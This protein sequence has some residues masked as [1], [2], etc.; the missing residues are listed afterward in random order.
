MSAREG[1]TGLEGLGEAAQK[2]PQDE[3]AARRKLKKQFTQA[4]FGFN[5][6]AWLDTCPN[7]RKRGMDQVDG[8]RKQ[9]YEDFRKKLDRKPT[10]TL[11]KHFSG[12]L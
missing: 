4:S 10:G 12:K 9:F 6:K 1:T 11:K 5:D 8:D 2:A 7:F 3:L